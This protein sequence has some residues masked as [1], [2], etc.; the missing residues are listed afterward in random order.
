M[1]HIT[2]NTTGYPLAWVQTRTTWS[3]IECNNYSIN[4][5]HLHTCG[6]FKAKDLVELEQ[7]NCFVELSPF[8]AYFSHPKRLHVLSE[9]RV[10][11]ISS[12]NA[13]HKSLTACLII[14]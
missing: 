4:P 2:K 12:I 13:K 7:R 3:G 10:G 11:F 14:M 8:K 6:G 1:Y 9:N 5:P